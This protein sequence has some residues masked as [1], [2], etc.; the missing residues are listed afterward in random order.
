ME[1]VNQ[2]NLDSDKLEKY[3]KEVQA[4]PDLSVEEEKDLF[5]KIAKKED[6]EAIEKITKANLKLVV[7]IAKE[8]VGRN[9]NLTL[10]DLIQEG[11]LG[12]FK[13]IK[14]FDLEKSVK[15][16]FKVYATWW[17]RQSIT[18]KI[19]HDLGTDTRWFGGL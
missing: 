15:Y 18:R 5:E 17:I 8:Y 16:T 19:S 6:R 4:N 9:P 12:L 13:A 11:N 7:S 10:L 2:N 1:N 14:K 3:I